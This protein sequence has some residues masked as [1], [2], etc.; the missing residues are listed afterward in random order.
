MVIEPTAGHLFTYL[1][2]QEERGED[3]VSRVAGLAK[4]LV[5]LGGD[6]RREVERV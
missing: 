2:C 6:A 5:D 3:H 4:H 1:K